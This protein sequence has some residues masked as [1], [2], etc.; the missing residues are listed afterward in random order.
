M[1]KA[2]LKLL[3]TVNQKCSY[4]EYLNTRELI[5]QLVQD[6]DKLLED[7]QDKEK[8]KQDVTD[9]VVRLI[10]INTSILTGEINTLYFRVIRDFVEEQDK[11]IK[12]LH[13]HYDDKL[14][15]FKI[16]TKV[17]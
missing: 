8:Y 5:S 11:W 17:N 16:N 6:V 14:I 15:Q 2:K 1:L 4:E 13:R 7:E 9:A 3:K 12:L 10:N